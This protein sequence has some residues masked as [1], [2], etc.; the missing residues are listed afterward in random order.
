MTRPTDA[1]IARAFREMSRRTSIGQPWTL[2]YFVL[3]VNKSAERFDSEGGTFLQTEEVCD[4]GY[5]R[6]SL[7]CDDAHKKREELTTSPERVQIPA[8]SEHVAPFDRCPKC[9]AHMPVGQTCGGKDC[10]LRRDE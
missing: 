8:E 7:G 5:V 1:A 3:M 10:G 2:D 4:C 9:T 6:G